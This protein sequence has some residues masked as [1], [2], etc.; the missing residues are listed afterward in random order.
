MNDRLAGLLAHP[1]PEVRTSALE[2]IEALR[3]QGA[4]E[5]VRGL[6]ADPGLSPEARGRAVLAYCS[7]DEGA[8]VE[9]A[10]D[11][12]DNPEPT[13]ARAAM[14]GLLRPLRHRGSHEHGRAAA[15]PS[16]LPGGGGPG[17]GRAHP[18]RGRG[19]GL[20]PPRC[21]ACWPIPSPLVRRQALA[22][23][24]K[25]GSARLVPA[26]LPFL[27]QPATRFAAVRAIA[28][29]GDAGL[30]DLALALSRPG[31]GQEQALG[32]IK[33]AAR[34][35]SKAATAFLLENL[36]YPDVAARGLILAKLE[37]QGYQAG[38]EEDRTL[39]RNLLNQE[40]AFC[41]WLAQAMALLGAGPDTDLLRRALD[42]A[43]HEGVLRMLGII[44]FFCPPRSIRAVVANLKAGREKAA[45]ALELLDSLAPEEFRRLMHPLLEDLPQEERLSRLDKVYPGHKP[46]ASG[47]LA[48][49]AGQ[50]RARLGPWSRALA[51]Y[52]LGLPGEAR[53]AGGQAPELGQVLAQGLGDPS[54]V[55]RETAQWAM[56][57]MNPA[58][59]R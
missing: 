29:G 33:A 7:L 4:A 37:Q 26:L 9:L 41:A 47:L 54:A 11:L 24:E 21:A 5:K 34:L 16:A 57:R 35:Q 3:P 36:Y 49:V 30:P 17:R 44:A 10:M 1:S 6:I 43:M 22:A 18:G 32:V 12:L 59:A 15:G 55:V 46:E 14:T 38:D 19:Q 53:P 56:D 2:A 39:L 23:A 50:T 45:Y 42:Q 13:V 20:L 51:L 28:A 52:A 40:G 27:D 48:A 25:L 58:P 31:I 8:A